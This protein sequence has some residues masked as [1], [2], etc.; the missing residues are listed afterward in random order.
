[1]RLFYKTVQIFTIL[2]TL[3]NRKRQIS[4]GPGKINTF[5][6][7]LMDIIHFNLRNGGRIGVRGGSRD[8]LGP[9]HSN[10]GQL[11]QN[12]RSVVIG[13]NLMLIIVN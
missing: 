7:K 4:A 10:M 1:M 12:P 9:G 2:I 13:G 3:E 11:N 6:F 5:K 8:G